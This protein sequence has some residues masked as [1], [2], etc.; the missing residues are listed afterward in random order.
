MSSLRRFRRRLRKQLAISK[1]IDGL[2]SLV[3]PGCRHTQVKKRAGDKIAVLVSTTQYGADVLFKRGIVR[4]R[5]EVLRL[6]TGKE[7]ALQN[8]MQ[9]SV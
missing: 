6:V 1:R 5:V 7:V 9:T 4:G 3:G 8:A 2:A